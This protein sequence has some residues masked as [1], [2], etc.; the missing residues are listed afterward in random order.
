MTSPATHLRTVI[1]H[2][3]DLREALAIPAMVGA[4]G[5]GL[6]GYLAHQGDPATEEY[7]RAHAKHLRSKERDP[8]QL[9][10]RPAPVRIP[11]L[12]T[13]R[14]VEEALIEQA[15][16][17]ASAVQRPPMPL[18]PPTWPAA[19]RARRDQLAR[20]DALDPRRWKWTGHRTAQYAAL[21]LLARV[22]SK[23]GPFAALTEAQLD[24]VTRTAHACAERV[25]RALDISSE[26]RALERRCACGGRIDV[27][28]GAGRLP[29]AHCTG[30]GRVWTES[31]QAA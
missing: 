22:E 24:E 30:C 26:R 23:P 21:W 7:E 18:A 29:L 6:H 20:A 17:V 25:E 11:V 14:E 4:F 5:L 28:G 16:V 27:H 13:M 19:D 31:G 15:D 9:G 2:W 10:E 8:I 12:D 1:L 3:P